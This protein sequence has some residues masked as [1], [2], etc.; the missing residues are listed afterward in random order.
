MERKDEVL[1]FDKYFYGDGVTVV[2][3][4]QFPQEMLPEENLTITI[5][6]VKEDEREFIFIPNGKRYV[7]ICEELLNA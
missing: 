3:W 2:E 4:A 6:H 7:R 1:G 5:K